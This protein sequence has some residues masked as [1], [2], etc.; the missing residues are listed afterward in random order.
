MLHRYH[1]D[2]TLMLPQCYGRFQWRF[3][4][5]I[6]FSIVYK[7]GYVAE[8]LSRCESEKLWELYWRI[9][10]MLH[11]KVI[12]ML[13]FNITVMLYFSITKCNTK[14]DWKLLLLWCYSVTFYKYYI[15]IL[16]QCYNETSLLCY[17]IIFSNCSSETLSQCYIEVIQ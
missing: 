9:T 2:I 11:C 7:E 8:V 6:I 3:K 16:P 1:S 10:A 13:Y 14:H 17:R 15:E 12:V 4:I 5:R